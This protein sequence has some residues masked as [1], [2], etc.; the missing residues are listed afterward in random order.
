MELAGRATGVTIDPNIVGLNTRGDGLLSNGGNGIVVTDK[1]HHNIIGGDRQSVIAQNT[2]SGNDGYGLV[3]EGKA[4]HNQVFN[5][6]IGANIQGVHAGSKLPRVGN[7]RG[8]VLIAGD[9]RKN[10]LGYDG[11]KKIS[12]MISGNNG[13]GVTMRR[14]TSG[15]KVI[16][17]Y[18][19]VGR[20]GRCLVNDGPNVINRGTANKVRG[21]VTCSP[22]QRDGS[23]PKSTSPRST[24]SGGLG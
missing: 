20:R 8:G 1:A 17:N 16:R 9:A 10:V 24:S 15:N 2:V 12:K 19:G 22:S 6:F 23:T 11:Q 14:G 13:P 7:E 18:I 5:S 21:N 4:H 3:I